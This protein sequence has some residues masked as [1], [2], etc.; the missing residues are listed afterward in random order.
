MFFGVVHSD[1]RKV[2]AT[3]IPQLPARVHVICSGNFS[4]ETTLRM[5][6]YKGQFTGCDVSLYTCS[7]GAFLSCQPFEVALNLDVFP[8]FE[9]M[10]PFMATPEG[11]AA[12]IAVAFD[13]L[14]Y[15]VA[16]GSY[17]QRMW[18]T[19]VKQLPDL[20]SKSVDMLRHKRSILQVEQ[21]FPQCGWKRAQDIPEGPDDLAMCFPPT[22]AAGYE[23]MYKRV[24]TAFTWQQ[25]EFTQL[26]A[27]SQFSEVVCKRP[28]PWI[29]L[30][31][32]RQPDNEAIVGN[33][34]AQIHRSGEKDVLVYTNLQSKVMLTRRA[35]PMEADHYKRIA[36]SDVVTAD[37]KVT[38]HEIS[39]S[40]ANYIR[41]VYCSV[42]PIQGAAPF[43]FAVCLD[44]KLIGIVLF[45]QTNYDLIMD[46]EK[47]QP[48]TVVTLLADMAVSSE[49]HQR[50]SKLIVNSILSK[51][52]QD[53]ISKRV[54]QPI[55]W[56]FTVVFSANPVS[57]KYRGEY[58]IH[59]RHLEKSGDYKITYYARMGGKSLS[60]VF[61]QWFR[62]QYKRAS[63]P[64]LPAQ[65]SKPSSTESTEP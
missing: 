55:E 65:P 57:M 17:N 39:S 37:S 62:K 34:I 21:F 60:E 50:L 51:E 61:S 20:V 46:G 22:Y 59:T 13:M 12:C 43:P 25:P 11:K 58:K 35:M 45:R 2:I 9:A 26:T 15:D 29:V 5:N 24:S 48:L 53:Q 52:F 8:E 30:A 1:A 28:G 10:V 23:K 19:Y 41:A 3:L 16:K 6:G 32:S 27:G 49:V 40:Q 64:K 63:P 56:M 54:V 38:L 7:I 33:P 14:Q 44:G 42:K 36:D 4:V 47:R 31:E 18:R